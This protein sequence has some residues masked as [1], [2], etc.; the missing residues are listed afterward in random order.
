MIV[1]P[2]Y[3]LPKSS[4]TGSKQTEASKTEPNQTEG[5]I[6]AELPPS[7]VPGGRYGFGILTEVLTNRFADHLPYYRQ[8]DTF[9]RC[10]L[11]L[12]RSTLCN[13]TGHGSFLL[14]PLVA[15]MHRRLVASRYLGADDTTVRV[16][17]PN[18]PD[19]IRTGRFWLYRGFAQS[20]YNVFDFHESRSR[21]GPAKMLEAVYRL[22]DGGCLWGE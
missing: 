22:G 15:L 6:Q 9:A 17:D 11:E 14:E 5:I 4:K 18:H 1:R 20:P 3:A 16:I 19:G 8:Q 10:G 12:S 7:P 21:D 2:K 13:L